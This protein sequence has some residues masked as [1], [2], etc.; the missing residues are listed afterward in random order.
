MAQ[1]PQQHSLQR[2]FAR[3]ITSM[4][5]H[6]PTSWTPG[7]LLPHSLPI[8]TPSSGLQLLLASPCWPSLPHSNKWEVARGAAGQAATRPLLL[9][10]QR[11]W[12]CQAP[13]RLAQP[14][15]VTV[16]ANE[17]LPHPL[18]SFLRLFWRWSRPCIAL[19]EPVTAPTWCSS[20][21]S[22]SHAKTA[23]VDCSTST[24]FTTHTPLWLLSCNHRQRSQAIVHNH[25]PQGS[26]S[27]LESLSE[28]LLG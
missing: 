27:F 26:V 18:P 5:T 1:W 12:T 25:L 21:K 11:A 3:H 13:W 9:L 7:G 19:H 28:H 17:K 16:P 8:P 10:A 14:G 2:L 6:K 24:S 15:A 20:T 23:W 4:P 22:P